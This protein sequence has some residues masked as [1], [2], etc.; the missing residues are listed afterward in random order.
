MKTFLNAFPVPKG[1]FA[2]GADG[3]FRMFTLAH[4]LPLLILGGTI[5]L[6]FRFRKKIAASKHE[7]ILRNGIAIL[8]II[9]EMSYFWRLL[10][11]G[12]NIID[13]LPITICGWACT[14]G[15]FML[16]TK[17]RTMFGIVYYVG[18]G[19]SITALFYPTVLTANGPMRYRYYQYFL[20]HGLI[21]VSIFYMIFVHK[22]RPTLKLMIPAAAFLIVLAA[23]AI[24]VNLKYNIANGYIRDANYLFIAITEQ[25]FSI[26]TVF[27]PPALSYFFAF[28]VL[29]TLFFGSYLPWLIMDRKRGKRAESEKSKSSEPIS[30]AS[31]DIFA[32]AA[33]TDNVDT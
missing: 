30:T 24:P 14:I 13:H 3:E 20:E 18:L 2:N 19:F 22:F 29:S 26:A 11:V 32:E 10:Y 6:L 31:E 8:M 21:F 33:A 25:E 4:I 16:F 27:S 28:A 5:Y 12:G 1:F 7:S 17:N 9:M 23:I 15:A